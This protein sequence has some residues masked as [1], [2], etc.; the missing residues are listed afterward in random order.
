[1]Y[2]NIFVLENMDKNKGQQSDS[3]YK[4]HQYAS[5]EGNKKWKGKEKKR[6]GNIH[7]FK[8]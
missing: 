6:I 8:D 1:M 7:Q 5:K 4:H 3:K 2:A